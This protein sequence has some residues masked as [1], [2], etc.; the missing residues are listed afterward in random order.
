M[1]TTTPGN[2]VLMMGN[3]S[4]EGGEAA[5]GTSERKSEV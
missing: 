1:D 3:T 2:G 4:S 5:V